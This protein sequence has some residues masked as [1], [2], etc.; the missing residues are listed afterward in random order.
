MFALMGKLCKCLVLSGHRI[1]PKVGSTWP[2][3][4]KIR[5]RSETWSL[6]RT[7]TVGQEQ[8]KVRDMVLVQ[9]KHCNMKKLS[10]ARIKELFKRMNFKNIYKTIIEYRREVV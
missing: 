1:L 3:R 5:L 7:N 8:I 10:A 4:V 6:F 2:G 9:D